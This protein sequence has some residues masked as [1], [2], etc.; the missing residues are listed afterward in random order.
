M[1]RNLSSD[2]NLPFSL[3]KF[4]SSFQYLHNPR[5]SG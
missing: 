3:F 4:M 2:I 5:P 1:M